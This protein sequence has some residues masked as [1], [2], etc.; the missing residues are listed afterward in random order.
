M[1]KLLIIITFFALFAPSALALNYNS[2]TFVLTP[3]ENNFVST[4]DAFI[5]ITK[6]TTI[7]K[8]GTYQ[9]MNDIFFDEDICIEI[10]EVTNR[11]ITF[12]GNGYFIQGLGDAE[13]GIFIEDSENVIIKNTII[14][15]AEEG[16]VF[17]GVEDFVLKNSEIH[18]SGVCLILE[19]SEQGK[20]YDNH[21]SYCY[22]GAVDFDGVIDVVFRGN[23]LEKMGEYV[24]FF[25][26]VPSSK[27]ITIYNNYILT[28]GEKEVLWMSGAQNNTF[29]WNWDKVYGQNIVG[30]P[31]IG[32]NYWANTRGTD[33]SQKCADLDVDGIC[34]TANKVLG[35]YT[36]VDR[37]PLTIWRPE[38]NIL[39][40]KI[41]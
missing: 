2:S 19:L 40:I 33:I 38:R 16:I 35:K 13:T 31:Y 36:N 22:E 11:S 8:P 25:S 14:K 15:G 1:K 6:C 7:D 10:S 29:K 26:S 9:L 34:D 39:P 20:I 41:K 5:P 3:E 28:N 21:L 24:F 32:G 4:E 12:D 37:K 30:G 17:S 23:K 18:D 27:N